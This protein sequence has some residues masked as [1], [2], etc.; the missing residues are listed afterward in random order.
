MNEKRKVRVLLGEDE[1]HIRLLMKT[2]LES[3][4]CE[5]VGQAVNGAEAVEMHKKLNPEITLLDINMPVMDGLTALKAIKGEFPDSFVI[6]LS[7]LATMDV[8]RKC[9][10]AG[11]DNYL[12][13][14]TPIPEIKKMIK[15]SWLDA[16]QRSKQ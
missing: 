2:V 5:I 3:M 12:R 8:V 10:E 7:S 13:K 16:R 14:D 1:S 11:A 6:M 4:G 9:L 15:E